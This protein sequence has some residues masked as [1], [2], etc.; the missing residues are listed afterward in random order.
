MAE[1]LTAP[2]SEAEYHTY[3]LLKLPTAFAGDGVT[4][5]LN[6]S[7]AAFKQEFGIN[8]P[9]ESTA[10]T[11]V[12][13]F[14][15]RYANLDV[16]SAAIR[17]VLRYLPIISV[18]SVKWALLSAPTTWNTCSVFGTL[19]DSVLVSDSPFVRGD[20]GLF[21][22]VYTSGYATV[23]ADLKRACALM[24][25]HHLSYGFYPTQSGAIAS[26]DESWKELEKIANR[27]QRVR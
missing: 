13:E 12:Y 4:R 10:N 17:L 19:R 18:T 27:Y 26:P 15:S 6:Q 23:P 16:A 21:Q 25:H 9:I 14:P 1:V 2:I 22:V 24:V 5:L 11:D 8:Q 7:W 20:Y 3:N